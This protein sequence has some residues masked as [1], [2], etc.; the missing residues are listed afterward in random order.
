MPS[1]K[2][3]VIATN[4]R[5]KRLTKDRDAFKAMRD[6]GIQPARLGGAAELQDRAHTKHEIETG[7]LVGNKSLATKIE[8]TVKELPR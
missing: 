5:E 8:Q 7:R 2:P 6:Q 4:E 1:R 3:E